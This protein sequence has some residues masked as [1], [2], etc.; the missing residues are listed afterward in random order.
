MTFQKTELN[1]NKDYV[2]KEQ[3]M[4]RDFE[5]EEQTIN[6]IKTLVKDIENAKENMTIYCKLMKEIFLSGSGKN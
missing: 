5:R 3:K 2:L 1:I 6:D 4:Y